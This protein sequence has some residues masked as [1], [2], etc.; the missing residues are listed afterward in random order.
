MFG[1]SSPYGAGVGISKQLVIDPNIKDVLGK[2]EITKPEDIEKLPLRKLLTPSEAIVPLSLNHD[3]APRLLMGQGQNAQ[4]L[5]I[6]EGDPMNV[7]YGY[8]LM[9]PKL[10]ADFVVRAKQDGVIY[11][12]DDHSIVVKYQDGTFEA[13]TS[14]V[15]ERNSGKSFYINNDMIINEG[16]KKGV[17][18]KK[19]D[20]LMYNRFFFKKKNGELIYVMGAMLNVA[21]MSGDALYEDSIAVA[22]SA[23]KKTATRITKRYNVKLSSTHRVNS[24]VNVGDTV[25]S[26]D[27]LLSYTKGTDNE[28][29]NNFLSNMDDEDSIS[30][31]KKRNKVAGRVYDVKIYYTGD[32]TTFSASILSMIKTI[33]AR[34]S[35]IEKNINTYGTKLDKLIRTSSSKKVPPRSKVGGFKIGEDE[36]VIEFFVESTDY[37]SIGDKV[38]VFSALKGITSVVIPDKSMPVGLIS[39]KRADLMMR[40][41]SLGARKIHS[42]HIVGAL[43]KVLNRLGLNM[44]NMLKA[45]KSLDSIFEYMYSILHII[46]PN[47]YNVNLYKNKIKGMS[48]LTKIQFIETGFIR[49]FIDDMYKEPKLEDCLKACDMLNV[50]TMEKLTL[51]FLTEDDDENDDHVVTD[52]EMLFIEISVKRLYQ[53]ISKENSISSDITHRDKTN[54]VM[55]DSKSARISDVEVMA[56]LAQGVDL[57]V[58]EMMTVRADYTVAKDD[59]YNEIMD[60]GEVEDLPVSINHPENKQSLQTLYWMYYGMWIKTNLMEI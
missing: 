27:T 39:G 32:I 14:E 54:Q 48:N 29:L 28:Y 58:K 37:V 1:V 12:L 55:G 43:N 26:A 24:F 41:V 2:V 33:D 17:K 47:D 49:V 59:F 7:T 31:M 16:I 11:E 52:K 21:I 34:N 25:K 3:D 5:P 22:Q 56:G 51:P 18:F 40:A 60:T 13:Y 15:L 9:I 42:I 46:E 45:G 10:S 20:V 4:T 8:D 6:A 50:P 36:V 30:T 19:E 35:V 23:C 57:A 38:S 44:Q 53:I